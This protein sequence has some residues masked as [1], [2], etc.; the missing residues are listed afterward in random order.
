MAP[1]V[2]IVFAAL[3][4][5]QDPGAAK[6]PGAAQPPDAPPAEAKLRRLE[7]VTW[8]PVTDELT[9]VVSTGVKSAGSYQPGAKETY[10]IQLESASMKFHD[11][12][13]SFGADEAERV[14]TLVD[15][16]SRYAVESTVWWEAGFGKK[17]EKEEPAPG[18]NKVE[19][20][21]PN[22]VAK[23]AG[24]TAEGSRQGGNTARFQFDFDDSP[25]PRPS[26]QSFQ[27]EAFSRLLGLVSPAR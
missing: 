2:L 17:P 10:S 5:G 23:P 16:L 24:A 15:I 19:N 22:P 26:L 7:A 4:W 13:R 6:A 25:L 20:K 14:H 21:N 11:E 9:W 27:F 1:V 18:Q 12:T 8:N 3:G